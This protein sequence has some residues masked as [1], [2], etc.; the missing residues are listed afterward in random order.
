LSALVYWRSECEFE[1]PIGK[2]TISGN[3]ISKYSVYYPAGASDSVR[4]AAENISLYIEEATGV[5]IPVKEGR[6]NEFGIILETVKSNA[7]FDD[8]YTVKSVG[9]NVVIS[10]HENAGVIYGA[11]DFIENCIGWRLNSDTVD[12]I[13]PTDKVDI[14]GLDYSVDPLIDFRYRSWDQIVPSRIP[15]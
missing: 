11:V 8:S 15:V 12:Y 7:S 5:T 6:A 3:D 14:K 4:A 2:L 9:S 1:Y 10:G 13:E